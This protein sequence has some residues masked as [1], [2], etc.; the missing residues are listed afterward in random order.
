M[1]DRNKGRQQPQN[2][3]G[4]P[5]GDPQA[6]YQN[7]RPRTREGAETRL[8]DRFSRDL[9]RMAALGALDPLVG[10]E[11]EVG[12]DLDYPADQEQPRP[13]RGARRG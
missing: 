6:L 1:M 7:E 2:T 5:G 8:T 10:R 9:T 4:R 11:Q 12:Q 3:A 13:Y